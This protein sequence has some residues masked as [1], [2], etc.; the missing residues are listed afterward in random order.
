LTKKGLLLGGIL[1]F[2]PIL[3]ILLSTGKTNFIRLGYYGHKTTHSITVNGK[4]KTDTV[5]YSVPPFSGINQFGDSV[6][7][8]KYEGQIYVADFFYTHGGKN[9]TVLTA[10]MQ[11]VQNEFKNYDSILF[12]SFSVDPLRDSVPA[13]AA[14]A[15]KALANSKRWSFIRGDQ[16]KMYA[17]QKNGYLLSVKDS[18]N[19]LLS[20]KLVLVDKSKH[21]RGIYTGTSITDVNRLID[22]IHVLIDEYY[23][24]RKSKKNTLDD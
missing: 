9:E 12:I 19:F 7:Q 17:L 10:E 8:K 21:I 6:S 15:K 1:L 20:S 22:G 14:Y 16:Q 3:F 4:E 13:L 18:D 2:P 24:H 23:V 5:Y 11:R